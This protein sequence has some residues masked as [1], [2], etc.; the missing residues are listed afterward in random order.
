MAMSE[1]WF[2]V[3][4]PDNPM[5][6]RID[7]IVY[8]QK[9]GDGCKMVT[10]DGTNHVFLA[11]SYADMMKRFEVEGCERVVKL[12]ADP[13]SVVIGLPEPFTPGTTAEEVF[14]KGAKVVAPK[15]EEKP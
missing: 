8:I 6:I 13:A 14:G 7:Q 3:L 15:I 2:L 12:T 1:R 11:V 9:V 5:A 10:T 4:P